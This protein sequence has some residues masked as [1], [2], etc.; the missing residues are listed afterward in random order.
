[1]NFSGWHFRR[2][3]IT[4]VLFNSFQTNI[5]FYSHH[6]KWSFRLRISSINVTKSSGNCESGFTFT[7]ENLIPKKILAVEGGGVIPLWVFQKM[8]LLKTGCNPRFCDFIIKS[9]VFPE[10]FIKIPQ[11]VQK[12]WKLSLSIL[13]IFINFHHIFC[14]F[15]HFLVTKK[16]MT[17]V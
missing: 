13:A 5:G 16:L 2:Y 17:S 12:I 3:C 11:V 15:W 10:I 9:H 6:K 7:E 1:M 14:I 4:H 8:Y